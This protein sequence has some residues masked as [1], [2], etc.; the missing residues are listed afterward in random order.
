VIVLLLAGGYWN[1]GVLAGIGSLGSSNEALHAALAVM[2]GTRN[3]TPSAGV[4]VDTESAFA[5]L[6]RLATSGALV[7]F[8]DITAVAAGV[9]STI[10]DLIGWEDDYFL[11]WWMMIVRDDGGAGAAPQGEYRR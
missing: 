2:L 7:H 9:S 4:L 10:A 3:V 5:L 11:G 8:G 6:R 1:N